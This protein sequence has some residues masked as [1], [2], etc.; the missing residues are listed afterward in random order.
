VNL[1]E[2]NLAQE[3]R[4]FAPDH[5]QVVR[6]KAQ[7]EVLRN[8]VNE[9]VTGVM[10]S[11]EN[12]LASQKA[13]IDKLQELVASAKKLDIQKAEDSRPYYNKKRELESLRVFERILG[14]KLAAERIDLTIPRT[15]RV[16]IVDKAQPGIKPVRP[17]KPLNIALGAFGGMILA[18]LVGGIAA[19]IAS[20][21]RK[22]T[23]LPTATS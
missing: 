2:Q 10:T 18:P 8:K 21:M 6:A 19:L 23:L 22:R 16:E 4:A 5:P 3:K 11:L 1:A 20:R 15:S 12:Q 9:S 17:N 13:G 7:L 14:T